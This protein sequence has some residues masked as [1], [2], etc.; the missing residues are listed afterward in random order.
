MLDSLLISIITINRNGW[1]LVILM[2]RL[3]ISH[4]IISFSYSLRPSTFSVK[5]MVNSNAFV[6]YSTH[7]SV[8]PLAM[9]DRCP[10]YDTNTEVIVG[11]RSN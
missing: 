10:G 2:L 11:G 3:K 5:N 1:F 6:I 9:T 4:I 8:S 7:N